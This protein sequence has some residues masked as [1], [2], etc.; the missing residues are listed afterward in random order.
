MES[1]TNKVNDLTVDDQENNEQIIQ[2]LIRLP[3]NVKPINYQLIFKPNDDYTEFDGTVQITLQV[4]SSED[5]KTIEL[6]KSSKMIAVSKVDFNNQ[7]DPNQVYEGEMLENDRYL[8]D[9]SSLSFKDQSLSFKSGETYVIRIEYVGKIRYGKFR[10]VFSQIDYGATENTHLKDIDSIEK[11]EDEK[12]R[13]YFMEN[14]QICTQLE[15]KFAR[16]LMPCLDEPS[17]KATFDVQIIIKN[18]HHVAISNGQILKVTEKEQTKERTYEY[19]QTPIMSTY[20]LCI[21]F[22]KFDKF[23]LKTS[24]D[25]DMNFYVQTGKVED[26]QEQADLAVRAFNFLEDYFN[27]NYPLPKIDMVSYNYFP[28]VAM[29]NWGILV[30]HY[31]LLRSNSKNCEELSF[32]RYQRTLCHEIC[33]QWFG[34]LVTME[35]WSDI[36]LNEGFSRFMEHYVMSKLQQEDKYI[37]PR[38]IREIMFSSMRQDS[39]LEKTHPIQIKIKGDEE[40]FDVFDTI[41]YNKG[42]SIV[43]MIYEYINNEELFKRCMRVYMSRF[44]YQNATSQDLFQ[45][46]EE[47]SGKPIVSV[48]QSWIELPCYPEIHVTRKSDTEFVMKQ[49]CFRQQS[50]SLLWTIP[51]KYRTSTG[52]AGQFIMSDKEF[53]FTLDG[54]QKKDVVHFNDGYSGFYVVNIPSKDKDKLFK[55]L[56]SGNVGFDN[57]SGAKAEQSIFAMKK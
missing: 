10:G 31:D 54:L 36:W 16:H 8:K 33:H 45:V 40:L 26:A 34:N 53:T 46:L 41:S 39:K 57:Q 6:H 56:C 42:S 9:V 24:R 50:D 12:D 18:Q 49:Q 30:F 1:L 20:L 22:G 14:N 2:K 4:T 17:Y 11:I 29:E 35:W 44:Q 47:V 21:V 19:A 27:I 25:I 43:R 7:S 32:F 52:M 23:T 48:F 5:I 13:E 37:W 28:A 55:L 51:I 15:D 3:N 38:F